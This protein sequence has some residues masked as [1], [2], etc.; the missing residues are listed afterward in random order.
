MDI[1]I[2]DFA[3]TNGLSMIGNDDFVTEEQL[4]GFVTLD[5]TQTITGAKLFSSQI[6]GTANIDIIG[7]GSNSIVGANNTITS[8]VTGTMNSLTSNILSIGGV[9][10]LTTGSTSNTLNATATNTIAI[11]GVNKITTTSTTTTL[12]NTTTNIQS[13]GATKISTNATANVINNVTSNALQIGGTAKITTTSA[14]TTLSNTAHTINGVTTFDVNPISATVPT[15][16]NELS[17]KKYVDDAIVAGDF[18]TK[19]TTQTISGAKTFSSVITGTGNITITGTGTNSMTSSLT[20]G[21]ANEI[22]ASGSLGGNRISVV[23]SVNL[24]EATGAGGSNTLTVT[25]G[26]NLLTATTGTNKMESTLNTTSKANYIKA[27]GLAGGNY[28]ES[29]EGGVNTLDAFD[30]FASNVLSVAGQPKI[31]TASGITTIENSVNDITATGGNN[32]LTAS[33]QNEFIIGSTTKFLMTSVQCT[34]TNKRNNRITDGTSIN[35]YVPT[36]TSGQINDSAQSQFRVWIGDASTYEEVINATS[37]TN[38]FNNATSNI[39]QI[40]GTTKLTINST[41]TTAVNKIIAP[42]YKI[43]TFASNLPLCSNS[44]SV[45]TFGSLS[46]SGVAANLQFPAQNSSG[47]LI[48]QFIFPFDVTVHYIT[49]HSSQNASTA[50][51]SLVLSFASGFVYSTP[52]FTSPTAATAQSIYV[53]GSAG[54]PI[55]ENVAAN[56]AFFGTVTPTGSSATSKNWSFF[57]YYSQR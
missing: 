9:A 28:I 42:T 4:A 46:V 5:T 36:F 56:S 25:S 44:F 30:V 24:I 35:A 50:S 53:A 14:L 37:A 47:T 19:T 54:S 27:E 18:V 8:S 16:N 45:T 31:T 11:N 13:G 48:G 12:N 3:Q 57:I 20:N 38:T 33:S 32:T 7:S 55:N 52:A 40:A 41:A 34:L 29:G 15:T 23:N 22:V 1:I 17:N 43:G 26:Q 6:V 10:K 2:M 39:L 51:Q 21:A 49:G